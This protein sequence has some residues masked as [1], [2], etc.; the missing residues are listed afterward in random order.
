MLNADIDTDTAPP[1]P[2][3]PPVRFAGFALAWAAFWLLLLTVEAQ[4][5]WR[6]GGRALWKP[7]LWEGSSCVV[8][9]GFVWLQWRNAHRLDTRL[10]QPWHW[11]ARALAPLPVVA[12]M[13]VTLVYALRHGTYALL[14]LDYRHDGWV[15]VYAYEMLK[16]GAFY[17]MF[18]AIFFGL[19]SHAA[20]GVARLRAERER[21]LA[22]HAQLLQLAQQIEPHFLFNALN[23]IAST[24]HADPDLADSL[25]TSLAALL[26]ATTDLARRGEAT[27][28]E[29]LHLLEGYAAIMRRRFGERVD[30][31]FEI[32]PAARDCVLPTLLIQ[33]LL[34]NAFRHGVETRSATTHIVVSAARDGERLRLAVTDDAGTLPAEP[35]PGVGIGN[36]RERLAARHGAA[37]S[38]VLRPREGGGVIAAVELPCGC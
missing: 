37:A 27:L 36:L 10:V 8:A 12:P 5:F 18:A 2:G 3:L 35:V 19:R 6:S 16:F 23:T 28:A 9:S 26:R 38:L 34:E 22:Q 15:S 21:R 11:F 17:L 31:R 30:L 14:G 32:D 25:L 29:E 13:F 4:D 20:L 33:P 24:I 7:L 1:D